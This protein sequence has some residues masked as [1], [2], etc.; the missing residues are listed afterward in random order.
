MRNKRDC[1]EITL[2][3]FSQRVGIT[4]FPLLYALNIKRQHF[5]LCKLQIYF[6][7]ARFVVIV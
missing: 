4:S 3:V 6:A 1:L 2:C 7:L 5:C